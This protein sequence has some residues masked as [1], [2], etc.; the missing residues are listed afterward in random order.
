MESTGER[1]SGASR[2]ERGRR[3]LRAW[4]RL[5]MPPEDF[6]TAARLLAGLARAEPEPAPV[7]RLAAAGRELLDLRHFAERTREMIDEGEL[8]LFSLSEEHALVDA[9]RAT[10][11]LIAR[12]EAHLGPFPRGDAPGRRS[13]VRHT[14]LVEVD[15]EH[16]ASARWA[17]ECALQASDAPTP[18]EPVGR[19][20]LRA[21]GEDLRE[22]ERF[23]SAQPIE[24][25]AG[26]LRE[27]VL[28]VA[29]GCGEIAGALE[30]AS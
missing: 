4:C 6:D 5:E 20:M 23:L 28:E 1:R 30:N 11:E 8:R 19:L 16:H 21:I 7:L 3:G 24:G 10:G 26:E 17:V 14:F 9:L 12:I 22:V 13:G 18:A 25:E 27:L 15:P 29:T 2:I